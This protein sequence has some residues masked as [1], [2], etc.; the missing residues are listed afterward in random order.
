M[1]SH[2][3]EERPDRESKIPFAAMGGL[4]GL[5]LLAGAPNAQAQ[6]DQPAQYAPSGWIGTPNP[7]FTWGTVAGPVT[8][9]VV[10]LWVPGGSSHYFQEWFA[11]GAYCSGST[12]SAGLSTALPLGHYDWYVRARTSS[13]WWGYWSLPGLGFDV[14]GPPA[15]TLYAP[16]GSITAPY[17]TYTWSNVGG[18]VTLS[19]AAPPTRAEHR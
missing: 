3:P 9:Y 15:P 13:G 18:A 11:P 14:A 17:P 6:A 19:R 10:E 1:L 4:L 16:N 8:Y 2:A 7:T 5:L 12:C